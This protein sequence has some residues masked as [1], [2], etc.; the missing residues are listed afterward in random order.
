MRL[1]ARKPRDKDRFFLAC[2]DTP[3]FSG[4]GV[5]QICVEISEDG[6]KIHIPL[7][8]ITM[9]IKSTATWSKGIEGVCRSA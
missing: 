7:R 5:T 9:S 2:A 8:R 4:V 1:T 6:I 3:F